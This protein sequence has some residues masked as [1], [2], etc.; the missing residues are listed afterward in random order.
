MEIHSGQQEFLRGYDISNLSSQDELHQ[1]AIST[2][3]DTDSPKELLKTT[4][5]ILSFLNEAQRMYSAVPIEMFE[6]GPQGVKLQGETLEPGTPIIRMTRFC[7][8]NPNAPSPYVKPGPNG[9]DA[10]VFVPRRWLL[11]D[12][13][14]NVTGCETPDNKH[15]GF[16]AFGCGLNIRDCPGRFYADVAMVYMVGMI[17]KEYSIKLEDGHPPVGRVMGLTESV[18]R[19]LSVVLT[20]RK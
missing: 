3:L 13:H 6:A 12:D 7:G 16:L 20:K 8:L 17:M 10:T 9:E 11:Y 2:N 19:E 14:G 18:D 15:A 5:R 4:P 1:E